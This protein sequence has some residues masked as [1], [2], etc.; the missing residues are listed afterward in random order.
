MIK[1]ITSV[2]R[3]SF[4]LSLIS[5]SGLAAAPSGFLNCYN[6]MQSP[7]PAAHFF[8]VPL[9]EKDTLGVRAGPIASQFRAPKS[10]TA[11]IVTPKTILKRKFS[12]DTA[13][14]LGMEPNPRGGGLVQVNGSPIFEEK[15]FF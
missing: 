12:Y 11:Y 15:T 3:I 14:D 5:C 6:E 1:G 7:L 13:E 10:E 2:I 9:T 4:T 8:G